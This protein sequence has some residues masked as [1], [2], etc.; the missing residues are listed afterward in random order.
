M[1]WLTRSRRV[2]N[3]VYVGVSLK[4]L[5][6]QVRLVIISTLIGVW[7]NVDLVQTIAY[8][9]SYFYMFGLCW[10]LKHPKEGKIFFDG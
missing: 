8:S 1:Q 9:A 2:N 6:S 10:L 4:K 7:L 5:K 3:K